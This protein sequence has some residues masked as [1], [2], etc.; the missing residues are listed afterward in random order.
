MEGAYTHPSVGKVDG[1]YVQVYCIYVYMYVFVFILYSCI[2]CR[3][4]HTYNRSH[5]ADVIPTQAMR[6]LRSPQR[7]KELGKLY[8]SGLSGEHSVRWI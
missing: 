4:T 2:Y 3:A 7:Q 8:H 1:V 5:L 6:T